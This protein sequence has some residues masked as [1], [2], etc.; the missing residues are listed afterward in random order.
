[1]PTLR[2]SNA[3]ALDEIAWYR[4]NSGV[5]FELDNGYDSSDWPEKQYDHLRAGT[6]PVAGK[7]PNAWGLYDMLGNVYEWCQD[8]IRQYASGDVTDPLGPT[9]SGA[10][11]ALRGGGWGSPARYLRCAYR[12]AHHLGYRDDR[13]GFRPARVQQ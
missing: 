2:E 12:N 9:Q 4:G 5:D 1:M 3:P 13:I 8:A 10:G 7:S 11:R 6:H